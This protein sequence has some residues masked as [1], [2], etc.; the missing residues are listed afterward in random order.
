MKVPEGMKEIFEINPLLKY[1]TWVT[2]YFISE[3]DG[4]TE[5]SKERIRSFQEKITKLIQNSQKRSKEQKGKKA[6]NIHLATEK[7]KAR[8]DRYFNSALGLLRARL[9]IRMLQY[10]TPQ[11]KSNFLRDLGATIG[12]KVM[13]TFGN[14]IDVIFARNISIGDGS[15]LGMGAVL[16]CEEIIDG[17]LY[18]GNIEIG[19]NTLI[20]AGAIIMP[21][22]SIGNNCIVTPGIVSYDVPDNTLCVGLPED[23][24]V[25]LEGEKISLTDEKRKVQKT[26]WDLFD[27]KEFLPSLNSL[28]VKNIILQLQKLPI[29]QNLRQFLLRL[30]GMKIGENVI[31]EDNVNF[32]PWYPE[33]ITIEDGAKI[34]KYAVISTHEGMPPKESEIKGSFRVGEVIIGKNVLLESGTGVLPGVHIKDNAEI[35]PYTFIATDVSEGIQVEGIPSRKVG[36]TFDI[37]NF[38]AQSLGYTATAWDE[39]QQIR[40]EE[41]EEQLIEKQVEEEEKNIRHNREPEIKLPKPENEP[42]ITLSKPENEP[43][44]TLSKPEN[45]P[46]ITLPKPENEPGITLPKPENEPEITLPKPESEPEITL[47]KPE[48]EANKL[49]HIEENLEKSNKF[50]LKVLRSEKLKDNIIEYE[51]K[52]VE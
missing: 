1:A 40:L 45:E 31:I 41:E 46:E 51:E 50:K 2:P 9:Q 16:T 14:L 25:P 3:E 47:P 11:F 20:G 42:E 36:E 23:V 22:V 24:R 17:E 18:L 32:D 5:K 6:R 30:T 43:E 35:L 19:H 21:G 34:K 15:I 4:S 37:Q 52:N 33:R 48:E 29:T 13:I 44:I 12:N 8:W 10:G 39:I 26:P 38:M 27:W 7:E 49:D 28:L